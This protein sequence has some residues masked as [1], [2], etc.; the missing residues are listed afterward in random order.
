MKTLTENEIEEIKKLCNRA[1]ELCVRRSAFRKFGTKPSGQHTLDG[2]VVD[3][4]VEEL[5]SI[6]NSNTALLDA[7]LLGVLNRFVDY[8][9]RKGENDMPLK[10]DEASNEATRDV[11][12]GDLKMRIYKAIAMLGLPIW[13]VK[14]SNE[15]REKIRI[16]VAKMWCI[17][18]SRAEFDMALEK[19]I[20]EAGMVGKIEEDIASG[21][22][23]T[24][25]VVALK[26]GIKSRFKKMKNTPLKLLT[27]KDLLRDFWL[28]LRTFHGTS[29]ELFEKTLIECL[30][31]EYGYSIEALN[32]MKA[33]K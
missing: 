31:E 26:Q 5:E 6:R 18:F 4:P 15:A 24:V 14:D 22:K 33:T 16:E 28:E 11:F 21:N 27:D 1:F 17:C 13:V 8:T 3:I 19:V 30:H 9:E 20:E 23:D 29:L 32:A 12:F 2:V 7:E 25:V 10:P